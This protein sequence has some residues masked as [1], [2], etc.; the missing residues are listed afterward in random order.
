MKFKNVINEVVDMTRQQLPDSWKQAK[1]VWNK[2]ASMGKVYPSDYE[3]FI[4]FERFFSSFL[5]KN[6]RE[7]TIEDTLKTYIKTTNAQL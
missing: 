2:L 1:Y 5:E 7:P 4:S 3:G 6:G